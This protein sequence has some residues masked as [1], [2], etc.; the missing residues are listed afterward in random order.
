MSRKYR[1]FSKE[2]KLKVVHARLQ[3]KSVAEL[4]REHDIHPN[5]IYKW[6]QEYTAH[7]QTAFRTSPERDGESQGGAHTV[8]ELEQMIGRLTMENDFL[9]KALALAANA[10][11]T[12]SSPNTEPGAK[13]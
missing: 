8:A 5:M 13:V 3:G 4:V 7:P 1:T 9:K 2:F 10:S 6:V 11:T 12:P